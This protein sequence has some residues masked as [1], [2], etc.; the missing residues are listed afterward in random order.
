M[1]LK[2]LTLKKKFLK[3][4]V[5]PILDTRV[6]CKVALENSVYKA[7]TIG[8]YPEWNVKSINIEFYKKAV[9]IGIY[10]EWNVKFCG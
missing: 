1:R 9:S 2:I 7:L 6:E 10:P 5:Y 3:E 4:K 8:I